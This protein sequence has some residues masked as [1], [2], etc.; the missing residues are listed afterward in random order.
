MTHTESHIQQICIKWFRYQYPNDRLLLFAVPNGAKVSL[1][2]ARILKAEGL[3]AGVSDT[4]LL[5]ANSRYHGLCIEFKT[6]TGRQSPEQKEFQAS[7]E[8]A[9]YQYAIVRSFDDFDKLIKQYING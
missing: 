7:V 3:T 1:T 6:Q 9:G 4:I 8:A 5:K 2:H